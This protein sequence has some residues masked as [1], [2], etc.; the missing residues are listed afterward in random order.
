MPNACHDTRAQEIQ[1][2]R[3]LP[4]EQELTQIQVR[5]DTKTKT[6]ARKILNDLG[7]DLST[8]VKMFF[9]QIVRAKTLPLEVRDENGFRPHKA[10][11]LEE[12]S[13]DAKKNPKKFSSVDD[14]L[15][16]VLS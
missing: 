15:D 5:I 16:D 9:K 10:V 7:L 12:A 11:E 14:F 4:P 3:R 13:R 6:Q 8:A 1:R 2:C